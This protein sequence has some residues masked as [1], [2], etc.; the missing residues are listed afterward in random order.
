MRKEAQISSGDTSSRRVA[1]RYLMK[2]WNEDGRTNYEKSVE[3]SYV[4]GRTFI[5]PGMFWEVNL[6]T[7]VAASSSGHSLLFTLPCCPVLSPEFH[8]SGSQPSR[9]QFKEVF[10]VLWFRSL[11]KKRNLTRVSENF[12]MVQDVLRGRNANQSMLVTWW[13]VMASFVLNS[14]AKY[15]VLALCLWGPGHV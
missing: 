13:W 2:T 4:L 5:F 15:T 1:Y 12:D 8:G 3:D 11:G 6:R 10:V 9:H 14:V 7:V